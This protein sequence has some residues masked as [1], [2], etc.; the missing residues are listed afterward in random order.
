VDALLGPGRGRAP[1][2]HRTAAPA[3]PPAAAPA[4]ANESMRELEA[5]LDALQKQLEALSRRDDKDKPG[6]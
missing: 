3:A 6:G 2:R 1:R 4:P 5:R